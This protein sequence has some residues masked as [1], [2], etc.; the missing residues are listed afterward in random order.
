[1][2]LR[3]GAAV[4]ARSTASQ[5]RPDFPQERPAARGRGAGRG[6]RAAA[7]PSAEVAPSEI[8][9][10]RRARNPRDAPISSDDADDLSYD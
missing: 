1:M 2:L 9:D 4:G 10:R 6:R 3:A 5:G 7:P 8:L